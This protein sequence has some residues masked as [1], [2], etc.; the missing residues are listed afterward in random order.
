M[1]GKTLFFAPF[2]NYFVR[3]KCKAR[4]EVSSCSSVALHPNVKQ[5]HIFKGHIRAYAE[6]FSHHIFQIE[7]LIT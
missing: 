7:A 1:Q 6:N 3:F 2:Y 4:A 5:N